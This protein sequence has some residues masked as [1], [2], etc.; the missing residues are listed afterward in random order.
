MLLYILLWWFSEYSKVSHVL[1]LKRYQIQTSSSV[2]RAR[3]GPRSLRHFLRQ[4]TAEVM[5]RA[6]Y[7]QIIKPHSPLLSESA[8]IF[9]AVRFD[10]PVRRR[11]SHNYTPA[12]WNNNLIWTLYRRLEVYFRKVVVGLKGRIRQGLSL[13]RTI[14]Y[15]VVLS[16]FYDVFIG[17]GAL[18]RPG[19]E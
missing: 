10:N 15:R 1:S 12:A 2:A 9:I 13:G 16:L 3:A 17:R 8:T 7:A 19:N 5:P 6:H 4:N 14:R 11:G 18:Q